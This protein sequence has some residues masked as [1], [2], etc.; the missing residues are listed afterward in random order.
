MGA[1]LRTLRAEVSKQHRSYF[2]SL[3]IYLSTFLWP[4][5]ELLTLYYMYRPFTTEPRNL[6]AL[7]YHLG[8]I[9]VEAFLIVGY[10]GYTFFFSM[11][12][13]AWRFT[14]ERYQGTLELIL[15]TPASR[16][17]VLIGNA[18]ASL[19]ESIW[20]LTCFAVVS[21]LVLEPELLKTNIIMVFIGLV[22]LIVSSVAWGTLLNSFFLL[23]RDAGL[24][25]TLM[26]QPLYFFSGGPIPTNLFTNWMRVLSYGLPLTY[27]LNILRRILSREGLVSLSQV[28]SELVGLGILVTIMLGLSYVIILFAERHAKRTGTLNL[29]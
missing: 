26:Q 2:H 14:N 8:S 3:G 27:C 22:S 29:F 23:T 9:S 12:Q 7:R 20:L 4:V 11:I 24:F 21:L 13:S 19:F 15:L 17:A 28:I 5:L 6:H 16:F 10:V 25:F 1:F 18:A